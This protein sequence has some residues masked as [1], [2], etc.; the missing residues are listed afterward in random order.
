[1]LW[2]RGAREAPPLEI[3]TD[4]RLCDKKKRTTYDQETECLRRLPFWNKEQSKGINGTNLCTTDSVYTDT[5]DKGKGTPKKRRGDNP[6]V[7]HKHQR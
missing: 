6:V 5:P 3:T 2:G 1:M 4:K 7:T